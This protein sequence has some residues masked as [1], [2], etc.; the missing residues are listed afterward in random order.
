M[1]A[2]EEMVK[3]MTTIR[4]KDDLASMGVKAWRLPLQLNSHP[5]TDPSLVA[6]KNLIFKHLVLSPRS[7]LVKVSILAIQV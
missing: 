4:M 3:R 7:H 5:P 6:A 2:K 1:K